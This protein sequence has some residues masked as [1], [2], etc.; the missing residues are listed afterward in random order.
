MTRAMKAGEDVNLPPDYTP[1]DLVRTPPMDPDDADVKR[2]DMQPREED[3]PDEHAPLTLDLIN[4]NPK[5]SAQTDFTP[6]VSSFQNHGFS[7][8][9]NQGPFPPSH[10][11]SQNQSFFSS[12]Q[13][14]SPFIHNQ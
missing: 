7:P 14:H 4:H 9:Q 5:E 13:N 2:L 6:D 3:D 11:I 8:S 1:E 10:T 12:P